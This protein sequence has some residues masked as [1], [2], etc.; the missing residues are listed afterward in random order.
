MLTLTDARD[1]LN[2]KFAPW[3]RDLKLAVETLSPSSARLIL[4]CSERLSRVGGT[5]CG[6]AAYGVRRHGDGDCRF[7]RIR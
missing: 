6:Q 1:L 3:I 2:T 7:L 5:V 4:P